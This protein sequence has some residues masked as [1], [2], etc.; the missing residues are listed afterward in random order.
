MTDWMFFSLI[1]V[2]LWGIVGLLQK[3][4]TNRISAD[5]LLVWLMVGY[6]LLLPWLISRADF[7]NLAAIEIWVGI[8]AGITNGLGAWFLFAALEKGAKASIAVPL[9]ALNPIVTIF[10]ALAF[11]AEKL[12]TLQSVGVLLAIAA[13]VLISYETGAGRS[14]IED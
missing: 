2:V 12:T 9:T 4:G 13:G 14:K 10:L 3:L 7:S 11:L 5:S 6:L 8:L 1:A